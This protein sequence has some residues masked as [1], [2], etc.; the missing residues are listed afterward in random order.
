MEVSYEESSASIRVSGIE[1]IYFG[2]NTDFIKGCGI[3]SKL[4]VS[5]LSGVI[6]ENS[7]GINDELAV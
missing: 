5:L 7:V 1:S 3:F 4:S 2:L 6:Q